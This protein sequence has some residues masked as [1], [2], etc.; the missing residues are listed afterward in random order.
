MNNLVGDAQPVFPKRLL[1][2]FL[3]VW[4]AVLFIAI[5]TASLVAGLMG[6][7]QG[8]Q[9]GD[10]LLLLLG[11]LSLFVGVNGIAVFFIWGHTR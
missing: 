5:E 9:R 6:V 2:A 1:K 3:M 4:G 10:P 11:A 8:G 7:I